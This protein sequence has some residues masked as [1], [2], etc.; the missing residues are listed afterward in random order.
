MDRMNRIKTSIFSRE[1]LN[2]YALILCILSIL[3]I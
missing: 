3:L 2:W 1:F